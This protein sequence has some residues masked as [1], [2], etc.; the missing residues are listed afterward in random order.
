MPV[1]SNYTIMD[2][3]FLALISAFKEWRH[4]LKR[5]R[6][7][8]LVYTDH[9]NLEHLATARVA[10]QRQ[11][12]WAL[13]FTRFHVH[14]C[15]R[16]GTQ[17]KVIDACQ[18]L[19][20][21]L[22]EPPPILTLGTTELQQRVSTFLDLVQQQTLEEVLPPG[23]VVNPAFTQY[24]ALRFFGERLYVPAGPLQTMTLKASHDL[25]LADH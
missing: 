10:N 13:Y 25:S 16:P 4:Y 9:N 20:T 5:A 18:H 21:P 14:L 17:N 24:P 15:H 7:P 3:E 12:R 19:V 11:A 2:K 1:E 8:V 23:T 6:H 22:L